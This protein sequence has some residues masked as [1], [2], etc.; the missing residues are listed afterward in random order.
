MEE[1]EFL[2]DFEPLFT[3]L[4]LTATLIY[5]RRFSQCNV[6]IIHGK[7]LV[8]VRYIPSFADSNEDS[9]K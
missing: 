8:G 4:S 7:L 3:V 2:R 1:T 5:V 9:A 6:T